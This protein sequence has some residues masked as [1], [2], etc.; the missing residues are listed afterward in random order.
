MPKDNLK[1]FLRKVSYDDTHYFPKVL[2]CLKVIEDLPLK[3]R[4]LTLNI[5]FRIDKIP[6]EIKPIICKIIDT[7][8]INDIKR[9]PITDVHCSLISI[10]DFDSEELYLREDQKIMQFLDRIKSDLIFTKPYNF[11]ANV[12]YCGRESIALQIFPEEKLLQELNRLKEKIEGLLDGVFGRNQ[13]KMSWR[14][15]ELKLHG[16]DGP[17]HGAMNIIRFKNV[18]LDNADKLIKYITTFNNEAKETK[19]PKLRFKCYVS[20]VKSDHLFSKASKI[21][22]HNKLS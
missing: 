2:E 4:Y 13:N 19:Q 18:K 20:I 3:R 8:N 11:C 10:L 12:L 21:L 1:D 22:I 5:N 14:K 16:E 7:C 9:Q 6:T 17:D 15:N